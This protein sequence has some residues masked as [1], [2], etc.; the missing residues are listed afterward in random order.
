MGVYLEV[1]GRFGSSHIKT[2]DPLFGDATN[3]H[4]AARNGLD[5]V[6]KNPKFRKRNPET[7]EHT[8]TEKGQQPMLVALAVHDIS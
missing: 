8:S 5:S 7:L 3:G 1:L 2:D 4:C 6:F